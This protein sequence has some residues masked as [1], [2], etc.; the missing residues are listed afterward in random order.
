MK[1]ANMRQRLL[2]STVLMISQRGKDKPMLTF[3]K[4]WM[5]AGGNLH[6]CGFLCEILLRSE[7]ESGVNGIFEW[8]HKDNVMRIEQQIDGSWIVGDHNDPDFLLLLWKKGR[9]DCFDF[10]ISKT[11]LGLLKEFYMKYGVNA[12]E[13][14]IA[15]AEKKLDALPNSYK[16]IIV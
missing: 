11:E 3:E 12:M 16:C 6:G 15:Y 5:R 4:S 8:K 14:D 7:N 1:N 13:V 10:L 2:S 9:G